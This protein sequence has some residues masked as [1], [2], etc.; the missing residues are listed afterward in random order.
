MVAKQQDD[1]SCVYLTEISNTDSAEFLRG[2]SYYHLVDEIVLYLIPVSYR[3]R[4]TLTE[5]SSTAIGNFIK[6]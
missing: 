2:L 5:K 3:K 1:N 6:L 4:I